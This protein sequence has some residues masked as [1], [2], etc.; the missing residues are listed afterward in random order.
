M[1]KYVQ[2]VETSRQKEQVWQQ[3]VTCLGYDSRLGNHRLDAAQ[4]A[5]KSTPDI[6]RTLSR[7]AQEAHGA[8]QFAI[9][10]VFSYY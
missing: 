1:V 5:G 4:K 3:Y 8:F 7:S 2:I 6:I 10:S 9:F